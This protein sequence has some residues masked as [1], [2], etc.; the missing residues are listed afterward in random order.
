MGKTAGK[1][2][3][4]TVVLLMGIWQ[5]SSFL[6]CRELLPE[7][8]FKKENIEFSLQDL[9]HNDTGM[10][11][12][13]TRIF[14]NKIT[15]FLEVITRVYLQY[16]NPAFLVQIFSL[17]GLAGLIYGLSL[18]LK[19]ESG[20]Y[21]KLLGGWFFLTP[22]LMANLYLKVPVF[23]RMIL[24]FV[25]GII[26]GLYGWREFY[27]RNGGKTIRIFLALTAL[28]LI[29]KIGVGNPGLFCTR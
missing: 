19:K 16:F 27:R 23:G 20:R 9:I 3:I 12:L 14:H 11:V 6:S 7:Y 22:F 8:L 29:W 18:L 5:L 26:I 13:I 17:P 10:P 2:I 4:L 15:V 24:W 1:I 28:A 21:L 25:P